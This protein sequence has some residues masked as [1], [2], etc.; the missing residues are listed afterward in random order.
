MDGNEDL[1]AVSARPPRRTDA[2]RT[3]ARSPRLRRLLV[4]YLFFCV[5]EYA[6]W[7]AVLVW[8]YGVGGVRGASIIS[9]V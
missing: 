8:A 4:A 9:V 3:A 2:I 1:A 6:A 7:I 5:T